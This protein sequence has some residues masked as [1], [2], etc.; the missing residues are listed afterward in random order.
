MHHYLS[1]QIENAPLFIIEDRKCTVINQSIPK[2]HR[3]NP[4]QTDNSPFCIR[5]DQ[6]CTISDLKLRKLHCYYPEHTKVRRY[7]HKI[8]L[9]KVHHF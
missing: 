6:K 3:F 9:P 8:H 5:A 1:L 4:E 7:S 2:V